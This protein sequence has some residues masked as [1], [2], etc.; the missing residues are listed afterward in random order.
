[1]TGLPPSGL[2]ASLS[3][4]LWLVASLWIVAIVAHAL[5]APHEIVYAAFVFGLLS[6]IAEWLT[7]RRMRR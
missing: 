3:I 4:A 1:M 2:P 6:G 7:I 5:D